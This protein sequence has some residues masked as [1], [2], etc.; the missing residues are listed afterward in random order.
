MK[1]TPNIISFGDKDHLD[2]TL[3]PKSKGGADSIDSKLFTDRE[4]KR[5]AT[6]TTPATKK[7][8]TPKPNIIPP[9]KKPVTNNQNLFFKENKKN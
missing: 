1:Q 6:V 5:T 2:D 7:D 4:A 8:N 9:P 3:G